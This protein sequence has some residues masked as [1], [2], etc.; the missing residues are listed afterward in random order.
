VTSEPPDPDPGQ[1]RLSLEQIEHDHWG[2]PP[3]GA[4][5]LV[6][7]SLQLRRKPL[8]ELTPEDLR[9]LIGQQIS[10]SVLVPYALALLAKDPLTE[11]D[12]YPGDLLSAVM[13]LPASYWAAHRAHMTAVRNIATTARDTLAD[14][15]DDTDSLHT[16]ISAF[17][18]ET[19]PQ[20]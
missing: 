15:H 11:G 4:S 9:L 10:A 1:G 19:T 3:P 5:H 18:D 12:F 8:G 13:K 20:P 2:D 7:T 6:R 16:D 14:Q 17:L